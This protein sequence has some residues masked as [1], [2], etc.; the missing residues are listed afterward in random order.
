[1]IAKTNKAE[2]NRSII[3]P[4]VVL[5]LFLI[6]SLLTACARGRITTPDQTSMAGSER[7][8]EA[9]GDFH[10]EILAEKHGLCPGPDGKDM[11]FL[12]RGARLQLVL[13]FTQTPP[14]DIRAVDLIARIAHIN[15]PFARRTSKKTY[16]TDIID[17]GSLGYGLDTGPTPVFI[18]YK[19]RGGDLPLGTKGM[20]AIDT[21]PPPEPTGLN[22]LETG[23][24]Y[25]LLTWQD[26]RG[27]IRKYIVQKWG[28]DRWITLSSNFGAPPV[29]I[30]SKPQGRIRVMAVDCALNSVYSRGL[31]LGRGNTLSITRTGCGKNRY[32]AYSGAQVLINDGFVREYVSPWLKSNTRFADGEIN[33]LITER[34]EG[35]VPPGID[36][37]PQGRVEYYR[38]D[39]RWCAEV[40][41]TINRTHFMEWVRKRVKTSK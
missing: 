27:G 15:L 39:G 25:F 29:R 16:I 19:V 14:A 30:N 6:C 22:V 21:T 40:T 3:L 9:F 10:V 41:G 17:L 34:H 38:E 26:E 7:V 12:G 4:A 5:S 28:S 24:D 23:A 20:L 11:I 2:Y 8:S 37:T 35:W 18:L 31:V 13:R 1:M 33:V 36:Y 32:M